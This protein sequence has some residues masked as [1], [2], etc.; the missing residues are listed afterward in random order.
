MGDE[1]CNTYIT[2]FDSEQ[3]DFIT[4]NG[5]I[6]KTMET[7]QPTSFIIIQNT[8]IKL[9]TVFRQY[10]DLHSLMVLTSDPYTK[11]R[12]YLLLN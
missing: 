8:S 5:E 1:L 6:F 10:N 11:A 4:V 7:R 2:A 12:R 3:K 9:I